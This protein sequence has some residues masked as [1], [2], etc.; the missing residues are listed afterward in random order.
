MERQGNPEHVE[1]INKIVQ[2]YRKSKCYIVLVKKNIRAHVY[3]SLAHYYDGTYFNHMGSH[4]D[5]EYSRLSLEKFEKFNKFVHDLKPDMLT[6]K[7]TE[8][9]KERLIHALQNLYP[10]SMTKS[11]R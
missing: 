7:I 3:C 10:D 5:I 9:D 6:D 11:A 8:E 2:K 4:V 1:T